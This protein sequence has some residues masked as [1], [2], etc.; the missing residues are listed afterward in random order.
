VAGSSER[1]ATRARAGWGVTVYCG[2]EPLVSLGGG[3]GAGFTVTQ[4]NATAGGTRARVRVFSVLAWYLQYP[5]MPCPRRDGGFVCARVCAPVGGGA[6]VQAYQGGAPTD[7]D[8]PPATPFYN[9]GGGGGGGIIVNGQG[10]YNPTWGTDSDPS[11]AAPSGLWTT[12]APAAK[13]CFAAGNLTLVGARTR[14]MRRRR[15]AAAYA[16]GGASNAPAAAVQ[17]VVAAVVA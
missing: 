14:A 16:P 6:G 13:A 12:L 9:I 3:I 17:V 8:A 4:I 11:Q 7:D 2:T 5:A 1:R 15:G 10:T